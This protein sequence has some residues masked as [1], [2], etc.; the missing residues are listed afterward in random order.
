MNKKLLGVLAALLLV[1]A[2]VY[3]V[4]GQKEAAPKPLQLSDIDPNSYAGAEFLCTFRK[5][6][7]VYFFAD[8]AR[9]VLK[10]GAAEISTP[11]NSQLLGDTLT[12]SVSGYD[13]RLQKTGKTVVFEEGGGDSAPAT[14]NVRKS[15]SSITLTGDWTCS[16]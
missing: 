3:L 11:T 12:I 7:K 5:G 4:R 6:D 8:A 13:V 16:G 15:G 2:G 10:P 14:L 9:V 1:V